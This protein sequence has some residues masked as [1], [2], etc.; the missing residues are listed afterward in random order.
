MAE[1]FALYRQDPFWLWLALGCVFVALSLATGRGRLIWAA[2]AAVA[3]ALVEVAGLRVGLWVEIP[4]FLILCA[5]IYGVLFLRARPG[6]AASVPPSGP[7]QAPL[8][9]QTPAERRAATHS[10]PAVKPVTSNAERDARSAR[11]IGRIGRTTSEFV[12]GVG[13][14]W[15]DNA[16]WG[17]ELSR[18][19]GILPAGSPVRILR[20]IGGIRLQVE[21][22]QTG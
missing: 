10:R 14:V 4:L 9:F 21:G 3:V 2:L 13:R 16:E 22:L 1:L 19:E 8:Q 12:N 20:V 5:A 11:L 15:I 17:A 18:S 6:E 7:N